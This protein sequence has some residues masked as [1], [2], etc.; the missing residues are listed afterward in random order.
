MAKKILCI[1]GGGIRGIMPAIW[2]S[3]IEEK[4]GKSISEIFD[5]IAGTST[6]GILGMILATKDIAEKQKYSAKNSIRIYEDHGKEIFP[7]KTYQSLV[8]LN[9][10]IDQKY[11]SDG[12][13]NVLQSYLGMTEESKNL[14][15][16][17]MISAYD[18]QNA[19]PVIFKNWKERGGEKYTWELGRI[20]SAAPTYF[21]PYCF[22]HNKDNGVYID[23]GLFANN[24]SACAFV[25]ALKLFPREEIILIS[26]GTGILRRNLSLKESKDYGLAGWAQ[27]I[28]NIT[29]NGHNQMIHY[30]LK[31][32]AAHENSLLNYYR[33]QVPLGYGNDDM[34]DASFT[35]IL[36]LKTLADS[37][38]ESNHILFDKICNILKE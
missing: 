3:Y 26:L 31:Q 4:T 30:N 11:P 8:S 9:G 27:P 33:I 36:A 2:L 5:L 22:K 17:I 32:I 12:I 14:L 15:T 13:E 34:D 38:L 28:L 20:T 37:A 29:M 25:E 19:K 24:I 35:N 23:G 7:K 10:L 18:I 16:K 1:D 21:E 6:G